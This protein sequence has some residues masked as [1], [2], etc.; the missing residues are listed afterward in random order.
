MRQH[1]NLKGQ[2]LFELTITLSILSILLGASISSVNTLIKRERGKAAINRMVMATQEIRRLALSHRSAATLCPVTNGKACEGKWEGQLITF[3]G[4]SNS[5]AAIISTY[6]P[7]EQ[8]SIEWR[9]FRQDNFLEMQSNGLTLAQNG[10]FVY[11]PDDNDQHFAHA[12][13]INKS[14]R[15]R[16]AED[17]DGDGIRDLRKGEPIECR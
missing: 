11:C 5:G 13:I 7:L 2:T 1:C 15:A 6:A 8:G 16:L 3:V 14:G 4:R 10:T 9:S 17:L 12:L